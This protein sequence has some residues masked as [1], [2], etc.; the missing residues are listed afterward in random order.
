MKN[1]YCYHVFT[2]NTDEYVNTLKEAR[3]I[4]KKWRLQG[5]ENLRIYK[6]EFDEE[7]CINEDCI[8]SRGEW[9]Q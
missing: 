7:E 8:Y 6:E 2:D 9:P 1:K 3:Q 4:I 5:A